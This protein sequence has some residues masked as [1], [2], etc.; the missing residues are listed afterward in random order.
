MERVGHDGRMPTREQ[1][2]VDATPLHTDELPS[3]PQRDRLIPATAWLEAPAELLSL[4]EDLGHPVVGYIR[5]IGR[6]LV[7]RAG[8]AAGGEARYMALAR[9]D[10]SQRCTYRLHADG[11]GEGPGAD[12]AVHQR[13]RAWKESLRDN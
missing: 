12:G 6:W 11:S 9:D 5:R 1:L 7:W 2:P 13:F 10:L 8:P 3:T 4:G